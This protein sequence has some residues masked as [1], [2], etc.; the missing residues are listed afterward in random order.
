MALSLRDVQRDTIANRALRPPASRRRDHLR[1]LDRQTKEPARGGTQA[2][3]RA[4]LK[5][6]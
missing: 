1:R 6:I 3:L 5:S 2:N 4:D